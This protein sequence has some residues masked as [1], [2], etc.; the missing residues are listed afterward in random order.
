MLTILHSLRNPNVSGFRQFIKGE[1][2]L[3]PC[4]NYFDPENK[5]SYWI[6]KKGYTVARYCFSAK[7]G[8]Q[9]YQDKLI[10]DETFDS[11]IKMFEESLSN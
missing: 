2:V 8:L 1:Y 7:N 6:S 3:Y 9:V 10:T 5:I 4:R 11:Y